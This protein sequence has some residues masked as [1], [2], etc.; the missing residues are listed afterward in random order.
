MVFEKLKRDVGIIEYSMNVEAEMLTMSGQGDKDS[1][2][3][4][5]ND[6]LVLS[7]VN[8]EELEK[9]TNPDVIEGTVFIVYVH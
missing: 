5:I 9:E 7:W 3:E 2:T 8:L 1:S 6:G 4:V